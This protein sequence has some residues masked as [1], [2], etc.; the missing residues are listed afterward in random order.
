MNPLIIIPAYNEAKNLQR[1]MD[2]IRAHTSYDYIII[3]DCSK[4]DTVRLCEEHHYRYLNLPVNYGLSSAVQA[5]FKFALSHG[6]DAAVQFDGDGQHMAQYLPQMFDEIAHGANIVIGSR[7]VHEKKPVSP[8]MLGSRL[9]SMLI[10]MVS[11]KRI[12]DPT[13][14]MRA[15]DRE[16]MEE[17][18][19]GMNYPPEPDT[20]VYMLK[21]KRQIK[22]IQVKMQERTEGTSYLNPLRSL[23]YMLEMCISILLIQNFRKRG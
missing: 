1:V 4:D 13:S 6:Y 10:Y 19:L 3:N 23:T 5:G 14:G 16:T 11:G 21:K 15:F 2:D 12:S 8:R 7:F 9:L 20:L 17:Y 18:A 22:E